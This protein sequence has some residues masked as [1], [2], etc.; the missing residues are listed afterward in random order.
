[1]TLDAKLESEDEGLRP[2]REVQK[3]SV[4]VSHTHADR[5]LAGALK[6]LIDATYSGIVRTFFSSDPAPDGGIQPGDEWFQRIQRELVSAEA[7]WVLATKSSILRPWVYWEA[8]LGRAFCAG[9][10]VVLRV[11]ISAHEILSPLNQFQSYNGG[12]TDAGGIA[13]LVPKVGAQ[14][15][16][17]IPP[18]LVVSAT[19]EWIK[20]VEGYE[21]ETQKGTNDANLS[22]EQVTQL[23]A[24]VAR[25]EV[26]VNAVS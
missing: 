22:A 3:R 8:A 7:V 15:G 17:T 20:I 16:M 26:A 12:S 13:E 10:V 18:V 4:F 25:L 19:S 11:G 24:V 2:T 6:D 9:G 14:M 5:K 1:M 23:E 21:P